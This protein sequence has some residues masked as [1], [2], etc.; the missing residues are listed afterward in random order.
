MEYQRCFISKSAK[1]VPKTTTYATHLARHLS[2]FQELLVPGGALAVEQP[3]PLVEISYHVHNVNFK[4]A[5]V[6]IRSGAV[7][8]N[9]RHARPVHR[10]KALVHSPGDV[11][12]LG[13]H[14][15]PLV[16]LKNIKLPW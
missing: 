12:I 8:V 11:D 10:G 13:I 14:E 6:F 15:K 9:H 3:A 7:V 16:T 5:P 2:I 1:A 4:H